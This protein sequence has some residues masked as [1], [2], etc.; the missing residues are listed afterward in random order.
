M[1]TLIRVPFLLGTVALL[2]IA[3]AAVVFVSGDTVMG[4]QQ[5][6][7]VVDDGQTAVP[8]ANVSVE[9]AIQIALAHANGKVDDVDVE[10][11]GDDM[12]YKIEVGDTDVVID[13]A[14]GKVIKVEPD[15]DDHDHDQKQDTK[16][17]N[18]NQAA[19]II[20]PD[21]AIAIARTV[22]DGTVYEVELDEDDG[23]LEYDV[24]IG[25]YDVEIDAHTGE[26]LDIDHD[27]DDDDDDRK[28][29]DMS[30][31]TDIISPDDAIAIARTAADGPVHDIE[32]D[33][34]DGRLEYE[35]EIGNYEVEI[36]ALTGEILHVEHDD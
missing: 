31:N 12:V 3:V 18:E 11:H 13:A 21:D 26:I 24:E 8:E 9:R 14:D 34:D 1:R 32:L 6:N 10:R 17:N 15:D 2:L 25:A 22:A 7:V 4:Q 30:G 28:G 16:R 29:S 23:R 33:E 27:D 5:D 19:G 35:I 36:D 20:S